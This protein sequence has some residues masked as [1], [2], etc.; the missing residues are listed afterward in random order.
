M[1]AARITVGAVLFPALALGLAGVFL[2][3]ERWISKIP[4]SID[5]VP[6]TLAAVLLI[7][8]VFAALQHAEI[9]GAKTG[10]PYG[11]LVLTI[12]VTFIE[13]AIMASM[14]EHG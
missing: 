11:T 12:A 2:F 3:G 13:V 5:F 14:I 8:A 1:Q 6:S 10:E 9:L 4:A 7:G